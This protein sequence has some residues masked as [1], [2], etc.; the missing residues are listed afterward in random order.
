M[1]V[2]YDD[3][4]RRGV[5]TATS[6][7]CVR[8]AD[9]LAGKL[10][11]PS[12]AGIGNGSLRQYD[13]T[14]RTPTEHR[15]NPDIRRTRMITAEALTDH[16]DPPLAVDRALNAAERAAFF[17]HR[18]IGE[19]DGAH[20]AD[21]IDEANNAVLDQV[22][23]WWSTHA[24]KALAYL[25][26]LHELPE[27]LTQGLLSAALYATYAI[28]DADLG[29]RRRSAVEIASGAALRARGYAEAI[30]WAP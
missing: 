12:P 5:L 15:R 1:S 27:P 16:I 3:L 21:W 4:L 13:V 9:D 6:G 28:A 7:C 10:L 19:F 24:D 23:C 20:P 30:G 2:D 29:E 17:E 14:G 11:N 8:D 22:E 18:L 25:T 26:T